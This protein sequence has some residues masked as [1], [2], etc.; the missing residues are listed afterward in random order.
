MFFFTVG[1][2]YIAYLL[3]LI[4]RAYSELRSM[5]YFGI[6]SNDIL[7]F[8]FVSLFSIL[9]RFF[10]ISMLFLRSSFTFLNTACRCGFVGLRLCDSTTI[11]SWYF[12]RQLCLSSHHLLSFIRAIYGFIWS[13]KFLSIYDGLCICTGVST[14]IWS[15]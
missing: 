6:I 9:F 11:W 8:S 15:T 14:S 10:F 3:L 4:L 1:G 5:P 13:S 12:R 7:S 2:F